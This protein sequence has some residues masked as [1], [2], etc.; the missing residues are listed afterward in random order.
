MIHKFNWM[1]FK[2]PSGN[3]RRIYIYVNAGNCT[4]KKNNQRHF[5]QNDDHWSVW[6]SQ[7]RSLVRRT[8]SERGGERQFHKKLKKMGT[9]YFYKQNKM[10]KKIGCKANRKFWKRRNE[11]RGEEQL[12]IHLRIRQSFV[13]FLV[14][15]LSM[16]FQWSSKSFFCPTGW[17]K[18]LIL[19]LL[20]LSFSI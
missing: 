18:M 14:C 15:R 13:T 4:K 19:H 1:L 20:H 8:V 17:K 3:R 5:L 6:F 7:K 2:I 9:N 16:T 12:S 11:R 10:K